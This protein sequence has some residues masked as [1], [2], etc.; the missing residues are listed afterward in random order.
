MLSSCAKLLNELLS[1][2]HYWSRAVV[3]SQKRVVGGPQLGVHACSAG[4]GALS[5]SMMPQDGA[6]LGPGASGV[7]HGSRS[8]LPRGLVLE[9]LGLM[10]RVKSHQQWGR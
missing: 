5:T 10:G 3:G 8:A 9:L 2:Q 7:R 4:W 6:L 1:L